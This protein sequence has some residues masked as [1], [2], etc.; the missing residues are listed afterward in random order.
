MTQ[1]SPE[2]AS[3]IFMT[4]MEFQ[5]GGNVADGYL[6]YRDGQGKLHSKLLRNS[7]ECM[8]GDWGP[9]G[10]VAVIDPQ[11]NSGLVWELAQYQ[12]GG[13]FRVYPQRDDAALDLYL[14]RPRNVFAFDLYGERARTGSGEPAS[15]DE[16]ITILRDARA[17]CARL[18]VTL[19]P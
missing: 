1:D 2:P 8:S 4:R 19:E 3:D 14:S 13:F 16:T 11:T 12:N 6:V 18:G 5:V 15:H 17:W 7:W 9:S 10:L